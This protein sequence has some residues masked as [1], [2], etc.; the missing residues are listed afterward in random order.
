M[1]P[2][3]KFLYEASIPT[4]KVG[5][6]IFIGKWKNRKAII[7]GFSKDKNNQPIVNTDLGDV[8]VFKF[9]IQKLMEK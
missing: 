9:R 1:K 4:L 7:K 3:Q 2:I 6:L 5:D 8:S